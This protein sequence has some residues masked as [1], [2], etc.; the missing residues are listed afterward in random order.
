MRISTSLNQNTTFSIKTDSYIAENKWLVDWSKA[1]NP[2]LVI[3]C[4]SIEFN[5]SSTS[6]QFFRPAHNTVFFIESNKIVS[7][8]RVWIHIINPN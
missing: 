4:Y 6:N 2:C 1:S 3:F 5:L 8:R 7:Y